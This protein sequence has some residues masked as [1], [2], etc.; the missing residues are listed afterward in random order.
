MQASVNL[1]TIQFNLMKLS[2]DFKQQPNYLVGERNSPTELFYFH[3]KGRNFGLAGVGIYSKL[4]SFIM[5][6]VLSDS[7]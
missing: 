6:N 1:K 4:V 5:P 2:T 7:S 3:S